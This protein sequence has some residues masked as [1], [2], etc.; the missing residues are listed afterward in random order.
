MF[1]FY[2]QP[3]YNSRLLPKIGRSL[4]FA[5]CGLLL[6]GSSP[7]LESIL[8]G[9]WSNPSLDSTAHVTY[10]GDH[11]YFAHMEHPRDG[12]FTGAG[13]WRVEGNQIICRDYQHGE[14]K[15]DILKITQYELRIKGPD[16]IVST[17]E[18]TK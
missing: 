10:S 5:A 14:S 7:T 3:S 1:A 12:N 6:L 18:R 8:I 13:V 15:A 16:G 11:T 4:A 2:Y 9:E 17:Y